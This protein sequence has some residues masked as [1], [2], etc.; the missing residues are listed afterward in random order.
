MSGIIIPLYIGFRLNP[1]EERLMPLFY[2]QGDNTGA[3]IAVQGQ[4]RVPDLIKQRRAGLEDHGDLFTALHFALP[5]I[6]GPVR[7]HDI[8][9]GHKTLLHKAVCDLLRLI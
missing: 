9:A 6:H 7:A 1:A 8:G 4:Y 3:I 2:R 5:P